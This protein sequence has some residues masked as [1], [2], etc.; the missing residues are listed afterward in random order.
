MSARVAFAVAAH[1]DDIE[2]MMA[3]TLLLLKQAGFETHYLTIANGSC[4]SAEHNAATT[5]KLRRREAREAA[6]VLGATFHPSLVNDLE[7]FYAD[8]LL[9]RLAAVIREVQPSILLIHSPEDY[10]EDHTNACRLAVTAAFARGMRNYRTIPSR[11]TTD[12]SVTLYHGMPHGLADPLRGNI[13]PGSFANT[14]AVHQ[15]KRIALAAHQSQKNWLDVSQGIDSYLKI[16]DTMSLAVGKMSQRFKH[17]EG[18]RRH[19]HFGFCGPDDDPL[20]DALGKNYLVNRD[21]E[22]RLSKL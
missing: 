4:G 20:G 19:A 14:T 12:Q 1:P 5:A 15:T 2:F 6:R 21:Y 13:I 18:W 17:A 3:G 9:R 16:M 8:G 22:R 10:M 7:I 11:R